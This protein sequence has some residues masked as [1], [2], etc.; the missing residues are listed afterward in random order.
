M[1]CY[2]KAEGPTVSVPGTPE[3]S[4]HPLLE[5]PSSV[6]SMLSVSLSIRLI[7]I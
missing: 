3:D 4:Y 6:R 7:V 1:V 2:R 5:V